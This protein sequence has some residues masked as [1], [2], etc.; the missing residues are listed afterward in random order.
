M[1]RKEYRLTFFCILIGVLLLVSGCGDSGTKSDPESNTPSLTGTYMLDANALGMPLQVYL[2]IDENNSFRF[3]DKKEGGSDKGHGTIGKNGDL[4]MLIYSDSTTDAPKTATF[5]VSGGTLTFSTRVLY[6]NSGFAPNEEDP[7]NII[8]PQAK[9]LIYEEYLHEY[10]AELHTNNSTT[11]YSLTLSYGAQYSLKSVSDTGEA[12]DKGSFSV[13]GD[14]IT[15][16]SSRGNTYK[17]NFDAEGNL[18][19]ETDSAQ[20]I[21]STESLSLSRAI[22]ASYAS[23]YT[24][25][26]NGNAVKLTL[27]KL[28]HYVY[29]AGHFKEKGT[30]TGK[31]QSISLTSENNKTYTGKVIA[32]TLSIAL[33]VNET[34]KSENITLYGEQIQGV[35]TASTELTNGNT[36]EGQLT[37]NPNGT[38][39]LIVTVSG[40]VSHKESGTF[41]TVNDLTGASLVLESSNG[42][43]SSGIISGQGTINL[44]HLV[45]DAFTTAGFKYQPK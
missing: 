4:Y 3:S 12:V 20:T 39:E 17:G 35:H 2:L 27:D 7:D 13:E 19:F 5:T 21:A 23:V 40:S 43:Q 18:R 11:S 41:P 42:N 34:G 16:V 33:P 45:D 29:E 25:I 37:L 36:Y 22:T 24:G 10:V 8:Y 28:G 32:C 31:D 14:R 30:F 9:G 44:N 1:K 6:G 15:L 38:Y 26:S